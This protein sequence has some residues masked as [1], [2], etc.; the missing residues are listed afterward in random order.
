[1]TSVRELEKQVEVERLK[2]IHN[3]K[4]ASLGELSAG[5]AHEINNPLAIIA[6]SISVMRKSLNTPEKLEAKIGGLERACE[7]IA[8]IVKGL[9]KF[10][11]ANDRQ[12]Y[13]PCSLS[14]II[15]D[16]LTLTLPKANRDS[17]PIRAE[18][19]SQ[20]RVSCDELEIEQVIVNLVNN[21]LDAVRRLPARWVELTTYDDGPHVV[22][23]VR[24][25]GPGI[26]KEIEDKLFQPFF[27][28]KPIGEGTGLGLS[29]C[30][31]ILDQH[32]ATIA[33]RHEDPNTCFELR[34]LAYAGASSSND[35]EDDGDGDKPSKT[36]KSGKVDQGETDIAPA[37][38]C[39]A[40]TH[41]G[42]L[43]SV[44]EAFSWTADPENA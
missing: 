5:I 28:T 10:A 13:R 20:R 26:S 3:S 7:R 2:S 44:K 16:C 15:D 41:T 11:R 27:T 40:H 1:V 43:S 24:D 35:G 8:K 18:A 39:S 17:T 9:Q 21:A 34:F 33:L 42:W 37:A 29:I 30:K 25:A 6:G 22:L 23:L 19:T 12:D 38:S 4:L 32:K 31:G 36:G 14:S